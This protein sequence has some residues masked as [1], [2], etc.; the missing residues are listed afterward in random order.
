MTHMK[1]ENALHECR[2]QNKKMR[3]LNDVSQDQFYYF[4]EKHE[5]TS[6]YLEKYYLDKI[7]LDYQKH[8]ISYG[9]IGGDLWE[10]FEKNKNI[11]RY[12]ILYTD[13]YGKFQTTPEK[14]TESEFKTR[15]DGEIIQF[16]RFN[17]CSL[18][19]K[20]MELFEK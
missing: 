18:I 13:A 7:P 9:S 20:S 4:N 3:K 17:F 14:Y 6:T 5:F 11:K 8:Y 2:T 1:F 16:P 12:Q 10:I 15:F 19:E